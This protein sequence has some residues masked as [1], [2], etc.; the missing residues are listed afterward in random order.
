LTEQVVRVGDG[1][2]ICERCTIADTP[3][4]RMRGLLGR[5]GLE[6]DEGMLLRPAPSVQTFFMRFPIDVVFLDRDGAVVGVRREVRPWRSC[7]CRRARATLELRAGEAARRGV[8]VG[9]VLRRK[10]TGIAVQ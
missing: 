3:L 6:R 1:A 10:P 4:R 2:V 8:E 9:D 7:F 5:R